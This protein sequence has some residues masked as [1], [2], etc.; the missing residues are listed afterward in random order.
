MRRASLPM[1]LLACLLASPVSGATLYVSPAGSDTLSGESPATALQT[2][3]DAILRLASGDSLLF[4]SGTYELSNQGAESNLQ[5]WVLSLPGIVLIAAPGA[6]PVIDYSG[7]SNATT[8]GVIISEQA[9]DCAL[10]N[11]TFRRYGLVTGGF[12]EHLSVLGADG[13]VV[14]GCVWDACGTPPCIYVRRATGSVG[15]RLEDLAITDLSSTATAPYPRIRLHGDGEP[16][17]SELFIVDGLEIGSSA[18]LSTQRR[19][20]GILAERVDDLVLTDLAMYSIGYFSGATNYEAILLRGCTNSRLTRSSVL[21]YVGDRVNVPGGH[22]G[23]NSNGIEINESKGGIGEWPT[24]GDQ[25]S[26][27]VLVDSCMVWGMG[28]GYATYNSDRVT[29]RACWADSTQDDSFYEEH[30]SSDVTYRWC[31][32]HR[33][34]DNGFNPDATRTTIDHCTV[35]RS[36]N[37]PMNITGDTEDFRLTNSIV[38]DVEDDGILILAQAGAGIASIDCNLY[39]SPDEQERQNGFGFEGITGDFAAWQVAGFDPGG[40]LADPLF[41]SPGG[42]AYPL[43]SSSYDVLASSPA[44]DMACDGGTIG[45]FQGMPVTSIGPE[46]TVDGSRNAVSLAP[47]S[48]VV[49]QKALFRCLLLSAGTASLRIFDLRGRCVRSIHSGRALTAGHHEIS[50]DLASDTGQP[51]RPGVY[52]AELSV[53]DVGRATTR[54]IIVR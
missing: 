3:K 24:L 29:Y 16:A 49:A 25:R 34:G 23:S 14:R 10:V 18:D 13:L 40:M 9:D 44:I 5:N 43:Y 27:D 47:A 1:S 54:L 30:S 53:A 46:N 7:V 38:Y 4:L 21:S 31:V 39:W 6:K 19:S 42:R 2:V 33:S 12:R 17:T 45:A 51:A 26:S 22:D 37:I 32:S 20:A 8:N 41:A 11:L 36:Y 35:V 48:I 28:H 52:F 15:L 50:W